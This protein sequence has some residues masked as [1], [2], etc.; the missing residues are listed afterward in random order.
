MLTNDSNDWVCPSCK[1]ITSRSLRTMSPRWRHLLR[2]KVYEK[3]SSDPLLGTCIDGRY[4]LIDILGQGGFGTVY[5]CFDT[6]LASEFH[7]DNQQRGCRQPRR[8]K[9]NFAKKALHYLNSPLSMWSVYE[10]GEASGTLYMVLEPFE[11]YHSNNIWPK[12]VWLIDGTDRES[13]VRLGTRTHR[14]SCSSGFETFKHFVHKPGRTAHQ[15]DRLR[16]R[17][18]YAA[19]S[20]TSHPYRTCHWNSAIHGTRTTSS[21]SSGGS[22]N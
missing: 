6:M 13:V 7:Q 16:Y 2:S 9:T 10:T 21:E 15:I 17:E 1:T 14:W 20:E 11:A 18:I 12:V 5:L 19:P 4:H 22:S 3:Y 8:T